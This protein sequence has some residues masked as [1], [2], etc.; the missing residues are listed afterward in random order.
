MTSFDHHYGQHDGGRGL[1]LGT[2]V[3]DLEKRQEATVL[4]T[5]YQR[6]DGACSKQV[7]IFSNIASGSNTLQTKSLLANYSKIPMDSQTKHVHDIVGYLPEH[8]WHPCQ[9]AT[10]TQSYSARQSLEHTSI[11]LHWT[12]RLPGPST[13]TLTRIP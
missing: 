9:F 13:I 10:L 6:N 8:I 3:C 12:R 1:V 7:S 2:I 5:R 11:P 4:S